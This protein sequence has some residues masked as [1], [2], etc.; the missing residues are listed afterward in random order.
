MKTKIIIYDNKKCRFITEDLNLFK[1]I[2]KHLS[3]RIEG[4]E[5]TEAYKNGWNGITYLISDKGLFSLGLIENVKIFIKEN[6]IEYEIEDNRLPIQINEE[7]NISE[8]LKKLKIIPRDYQEKIVKACIENT[9]GIVRLC[10]GSGKTL[11]IALITA[12]LNKPTIIYVIGLDLLKQ[13]HDLF[14]S[15]FNEEIGY[16]GDGICNIKRINIASV[17]TIGRALSVKTP[18][19]EE[20]ISTEKY[21]ESHQYKILNMLKS[22]KVHVIDECQVIVANTLKEIYKNIDPEIILGY[23]GTPYRD[24]GSNLLS[25]SI[26]G[27]QIID[28]SAS[29]LIEKGFL[30]K[31]IIKF[32]PVPPI[33]LSTSNY[34]KV[35]KEYIVENSIRNK[36]ILKYT[37]ELIDKNY[38]TLVLF[39]QIIHGDILAEMFEKVGIR[40]SLLSGKDSL[41]IRDEV[42]RKINNNEIDVILASTIYDVGT[43]IP[44]ISALVLCGAG[45]SKLR[46]LQRVGRCVRKYEG[47]KRAIVIDFYDQSR[48]LKKHSLKRLSAYK[49]EPG[50]DLIIPKII[51]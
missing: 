40:F 23:S 20:D 8:N 27:Q 41:I 50:F 45:K 2:K 37:K 39:K 9:R 25:N 29:E 47:K 31:P 34:Q 11:C 46:S 36:L 12:K 6:N 5:Y 38:K 48:F 1:K 16:I 18:V 14:S 33:P 42:K 44:I 4:V 49:S 3:Y 35:Y 19:D 7:I 24:D 43:D 13:F 17:W 21:N 22:T 15:L 26:L 51:R 28:V 10:T 30:A 32:V